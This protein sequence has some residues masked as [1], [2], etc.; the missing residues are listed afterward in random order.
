MFEYTHVYIVSSTSETKKESPKI[1]DSVAACIS[2]Y[3]NHVNEIQNITHPRFQCEER[4]PRPVKR[5][6]GPSWPILVV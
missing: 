3:D 2:S 1:R 5:Q 6:V 4:R